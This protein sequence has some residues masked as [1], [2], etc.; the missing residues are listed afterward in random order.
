MSLEIGR[1]RYFLIFFLNFYEIFGL[2][3]RRVIKFRG[4]FR[5]MGGNLGLIGGGLVLEVIGY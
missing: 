5:V 4:K 3:V 1:L 2:E